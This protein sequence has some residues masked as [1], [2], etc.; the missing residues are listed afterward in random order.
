M[1]HGT[2]KRLLTY[3]ENTSL[4]SCNDLKKFEHKLIKLTE[5]YAK[6]LPSFSKHLRLQ[7]KVRSGVFNP[8]QEN[9]WI[10]IDWKNNLCESMNHIIKF[11]GELDKIE[12]ARP[13]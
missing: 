7:K 8:R 9:K 3:L 4:A 2:Y 1:S 13:N 6:L 5:K 11:Y 12:I 10:P